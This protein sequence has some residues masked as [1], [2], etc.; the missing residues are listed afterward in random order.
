MRAGPGYGVWTS[1][2]RSGR[3]PGFRHGGATVAELLDLVGCSHDAAFDPD[4]WPAVL[5]RDVDAVGGAC[6]IFQV[7]DRRTIRPVAQGDVGQ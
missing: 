6:G 7:R 4:L 5:E 1:L 2:G 3:L